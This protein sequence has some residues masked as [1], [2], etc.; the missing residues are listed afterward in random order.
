LLATPLT[1]VR[2]LPLAG[3][4]TPARL[5]RLGA[6]LVL[7]C[8]LTGL[9]GL[10]GGLSRQAAV[11]A[12]QGRRSALSQHAAELYRSL[13]DA[14]AMA[15]SG[16]VAGGVEPA[17]TKARYD[18]DIARAAN[19]LSQAAGELAG[20]QSAGRLVA[21]LG[22]LA[23]QLPRY[24]ALIETARFYNRQGLPLGQ[25]YLGA[26]SA[27]MQ[28]TMLPSVQRLRAEQ[29]AALFDDYR[30]G[31]AIPFGVLLIGAATLAGLL[32][33]GVRER[34]RTNRVIN[35]G[36]VAATV[37]IALAL[38]WWLGA[39]VITEVR[40]HQAG[41]HD[42]AVT[43]LDDARA[44]VLQARGNESLVLVARGGARVSD[45]GFTARLDQVL[46]QHG[47]L[48]A[49]SAAAGSS[50]SVGSAGYV[51]SGDVVAI[52]R[53]RAEA[54]RW[55]LAHQALRRLDDNGQYTAAVASSIGTAPGGSGRT[56]GRLDAAFDR[57]LAEQRAA[58]GT[59]ATRAAA[60][61]TGLAAGPAVLALLAA[62]AS[63]AGIAAR[64]RE[65]R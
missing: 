62:A 44:A 55:W 5:T 59:A 16:Y 30:G 58:A 34:R 4:T 29:T 14:D 18:V 33:A 54:T 49:A 28:Q 31:G 26:G 21:V 37:L 57:A 32:D 46:G 17:A 15:T 65:Y 9:L 35:P 42:R 61:L 56:F 22:Q 40:L 3:S 1:K 38:L 43:A 51:G 36:L 2:E 10:L 8:L 19:R 7:G 63:A 13:A 64:V 53:V 24:T 47:L 23:G 50:G 48:D 12:G 39:C 52:D 25:S 11:D 41:R 60:A 45:A 20:D 27:L 6:V